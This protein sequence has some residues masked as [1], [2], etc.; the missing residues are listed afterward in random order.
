MVIG[1]QNRRRA[2]QPRAVESFGEQAEDALN[3]FA[4]LDYA[5]HDCYREPAPPDDVEDDIWLVAQGNL[6]WLIYAALQAVKDARDVRVNA[7]DIRRRQRL[8]S[9]RPQG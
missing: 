1:S 8:E 4:L 9:P 5:W 3:V 2:R 6:D 7:D